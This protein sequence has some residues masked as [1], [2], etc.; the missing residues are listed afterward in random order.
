MRRLVYAFLTAVLVAC[1][2][3]G[4]SADRATTPLK[5]GAS[6]APTKIVF[7]GNSL[8]LHVES[9]ELGWPNH[10]GMAA[11]AQRNDYAHLTGFALGV[12]VTVINMSGLETGTPTHVERLPEI[13]RSIDRDT[14]V[15]VQLGD[16]VPAAA[17]NDFKPAYGRLLETAKGSARLACVST[18]WRN[19]AT[20]AFIR[21]QCT[22]RDGRY[23][24][25][26]DIHTDPASQDGQGPRFAIAAVNA[27]PHDWGMARIAQRLVQALR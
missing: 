17:L 26:G 20:D 19:T 5:T 16:N 6:S 25:I 15:V 10:W 2:G 27:H 8:T 14:F 24:Y 13:A 22:L 1:D 18:W 21:E 23:V 9:V 12:P 4:L 3:A 11:S 7:V